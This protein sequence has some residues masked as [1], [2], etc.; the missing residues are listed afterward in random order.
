MGARGLHGSGGVIKHHPAQ[1]GQFRGLDLGSAFPQFGH[2]LGQHGHVIAGPEGRNGEHPLH[3]R[4]FQGT[5]QFS[6]PVGGVDI[7]QNRA[8]AGSGQLQQQPFHIV[9]G[10]DADTIALGETKPKKTPGETHD[11]LIKLSVSQALFLGQRHHRLALGK[12]RSDGG[13]MLGDGDLEKRL[14][15]A[16]PEIAFALFRHFFLSR[17][18]AR[19]GFSS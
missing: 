5:G 11:F 17:V 13:H 3:L 12:A 8:D 18:H 9:C 14:L 19:P 1:M 10:P 7:D 2:D 15:A 16:A 4:A 6:R